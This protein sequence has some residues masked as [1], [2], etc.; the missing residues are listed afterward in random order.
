MEEEQRMTTA[1]QHQGERRFKGADWFD[2][3]LT[4]HVQGVMRDDEDVRLGYQPGRLPKDYLE[5]L[6]LLQDDFKQVWIKMTWVWQKYAREKSEVHQ[7]FA[8][9]TDL[10]EGTR[11]MLEEHYNKLKEG[12]PSPPPIAVNDD[13][14]KEGGNDGSPIDYIKPAFQWN[15]RDESMFVQDGALHG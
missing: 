15:P 4:K 7:W 12:D 3:E 10:V 6:E 1:D 11:F 5:A 8:V 2:S 14:K 9:I 13:A